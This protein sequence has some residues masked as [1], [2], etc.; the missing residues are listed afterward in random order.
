MVAGE[1]GKCQRVTFQEPMEVVEALRMVLW[2]WVD[3][4][5]VGWV[6][7][8]A[9]AF[10]EYLDF[11]EFLAFLELLVFLELLKAY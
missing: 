2:A 6:V 9:W 3:T 8:G 1:V 11:L 10:L 5:Q 7:P 4:D